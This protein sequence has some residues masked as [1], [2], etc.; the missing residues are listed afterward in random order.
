M[1]K[2]LYVLGIFLTVLYLAGAQAAYAGFGITPPYVRNTSLT[3]NSIYEQQVLLV[4]SDPTSPLNATISIDAP[5]IA[6]WIEILEGDVVALPVGEKKVPITVRVTVPEDVEFKRYTGKMRIRTAPPP[7]DESV[8]SV[9]IT[10]GAQVDIDLTIIDREIF[11]FRVRKIELPD[12]N[13]GHKVGWLYFPGKLRFGMRL[14]NTGNVDVAPSKVEFNIYDRTG[15]TLLETTRHRNR[16]EKIA[17]FA[18]EMVVAEIPT[19]LPAGKYLARYAIYN[20]DEIKQEGELTL[21]ILPYGS[22][23]AAGFGFAGLSF[24]HKVSVI[25]P[26]VT[27]LLLLGLLVVRRS[28]Y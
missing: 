24:P 4:R 17:P 9:N 1:V 28:R 14:E 26:I 3:K 8:G 2:Q 10:L 27:I 6:D 25:L 15:E 12:F 11:D 7:G 18:T 19:R 22:T 16:I 20:Q 21:S 23:Q 13:A 5:E